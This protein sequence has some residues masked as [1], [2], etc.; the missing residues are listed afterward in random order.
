MDPLIDDLVIL[1]LNAG[2]SGS[3]EL[4]D[5]SNA[6]K[7]DMELDVMSLL[8]NLDDDGDLGMGRMNRYKNLLTSNFSLLQYGQNSSFSFMLVFCMHNFCDLPNVVCAPLLH[9]FAD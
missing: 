2:D 7:M 4:K 6:N 8:R 9:C 5:R 3:S 1:T